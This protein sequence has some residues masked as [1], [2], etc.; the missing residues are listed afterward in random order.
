MSNDDEDEG[1]DVNETETYIGLDLVI[2]MYREEDSEGM[3]EENE[4]VC[5]TSDDEED[6][7]GNFEEIINDFELTVG[8]LFSS[9]VKFKRALKAYA[10]KRYFVY[11]L[12][13][14]TPQKF[15]A[16]CIVPNCPCLLVDV[17]LLELGFM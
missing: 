15:R 11:K 7:T 9:V 2:S 12:K 13:K 6:D 4:N 10:I 5:D 8:Q 1:V 17:F 3:F 14:C 16:T